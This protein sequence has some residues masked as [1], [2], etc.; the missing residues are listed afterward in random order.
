MDYN[1]L[2]GG[3]AGQGMETISGILARILH[4]KGFF[5]F[6]SK[7]YMSR[8]RGGH[9]FNQIRFGDRALSSHRDSLDLILALNGETLSLHRDRLVPG[10]R[11]LCDSKLGLEGEGILSLPLEEIAEEAGEKRASGTVA[12]GAILKLL[13]LDESH[14]RDVLE[15]VFPERLV[16][17][18]YQAAQ[19]GTGLLE[20]PASPD[21]PRAPGNAGRILIDGNESIALGALAAGCS[22]YAGYPMTPST[23]ILTYLAGKQREAGI[24]VEQAEDEIAAINMALGAFYAGARAMTGTSGGGFSLMVEGLSLAGMTETP[25]VI[26]DS[27]RPG[28]ATGFPTRTEQGDLSFVLTGGHGEFPRVVIALKDPEDAFF[29]TARAFNIAEQYQVPVLLLTDQY[30]ADCAV[31]TDA[32]DFSRITIERHLASEGDPREREYR[33]YRLTERGVSP[34]ILPGKVPGQVVLADSDEHNER[35]NITESATMRTAMMDKRMKK[36]EHLAEEME[37][38]EFLGQEGEVVLLA[39]GSMYGP[40][41]EAVG[42][43]EQDG[44][45][46]GALVFGDLWPLPRKMLLGLAARGTRFVNVELN[47]TGQLARLIRQETSILCEKSI[48][49]YDGRPMSSFEIARRVKEE[50]G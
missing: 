26:V 12:L 8:I 42:L 27:Q 40:V 11:I 32:Y 45:E 47:Y 29:Q 25:L 20:T 13:S 34:R 33:R 1:I 39:W 22:F 44:Y 7:D 38:P 14:L 19:R 46:V 49:K 15:A 50:V 3:A 6:A 21:P 23:G 37:E 10:G 31:S 18:N 35:G 30:L 17:I 9:N 43:L 36:M 28:P 5:V 24:V 16:E 41:K 48:L 2:I 4:R